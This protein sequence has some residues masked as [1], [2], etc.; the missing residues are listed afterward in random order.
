MKMDVKL[1][2]VYR[3]TMVQRYSFNP[4]VSNMTDLLEQLS[5]QIRQ[6]APFTFLQ[7]NVRV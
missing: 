1:Y 5:R 6:L 7:R 4:P 2:Q 3:C